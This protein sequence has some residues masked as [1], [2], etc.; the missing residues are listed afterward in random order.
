MKLSVVCLLKHGRRPDRKRAPKTSRPDT[1]I[2]SV[3]PRSHDM[4]VILGVLGDIARTPMV[5]ENG[6]SRAG[7]ETH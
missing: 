6:T 5:S 4:H 3:A 1:L 7:C 2:I